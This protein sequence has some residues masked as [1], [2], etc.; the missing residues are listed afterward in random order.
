MSAGSL[1]SAVESEIERDARGSDLRAFGEARGVE[2]PGDIERR[3]GEPV[4][5]VACEALEG[6]VDATRGRGLGRARRQPLAVD[7]LGDLEGFRGEAAR[8]VGVLEQEGVVRTE[9]G[10]SRRD[11]PG[12]GPDKAD[13]RMLFRL[14]GR[15]AR[16]EGE[17]RCS[18][19]GGM[20]HERIS[21]GE[22]I[23]TF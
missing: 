8:R 17:E 18:H 23:E 12:S 19:Q 10:R 5:A 16:H 11:R 1:G 3:V 20:R 13:D 9:G 2:G 15:N 22:F 6:L 14:N 7:P 21:A 4:T